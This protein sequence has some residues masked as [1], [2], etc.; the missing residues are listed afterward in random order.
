MLMNVS[1]HS[2]RSG[3]FI[4][5][6][7]PYLLRLSSALHTTMYTLPRSTFVVL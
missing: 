6:R 7:K 1:R 5:V 3:G 2:G 4:L